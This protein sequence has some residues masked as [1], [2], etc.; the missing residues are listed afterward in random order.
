MV[1]LHLNLVYL[2]SDSSSGMAKY[3]SLQSM[4]VKEYPD[5]IQLEMSRV[6]VILNFWY[7]MKLFVYFVDMIGRNSPSF[8]LGLAKNPEIA[9][10]PSGQQHR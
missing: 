10:G 6:V 3:A 8:F 7:T 2:A 5:L 9:P 4:E 1:P